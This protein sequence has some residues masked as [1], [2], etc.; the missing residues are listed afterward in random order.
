[1]TATGWVIGIQLS[2]TAMVG[3]YSYLLFDKHW[4][5]VSSIA[6]LYN[7]LAILGNIPFLGY[8]S[9]LYSLLDG[10]TAQATCNAWFGVAVLSDSGMCSGYISFVRVI[11]F[12]LIYVV[13]LQTFLAYTLYR[14]H[15]ELRAQ[16]K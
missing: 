3:L 7:L 13:A 12:F 2:F 14:E 11:V 8:S 10:G 9:N 5:F 16:Q 4:F 15:D 1:M 6:C